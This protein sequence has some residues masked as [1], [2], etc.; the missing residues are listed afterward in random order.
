MGKRKIFCKVWKTLLATVLLVT[1]LGAGASA[2]GTK[3][4]DM[5]RDANGA[6]VY[7][8]VEADYSTTVYHRFTVPSSGLLAVSGNQFN[9]YSGTAYGLS[10]SLCDS[11]FRPLDQYS[12]GAY[13]NASASDIEFYGVSAGTYY[14]KVSGEKM[15]S[16]AAAFEKVSD[17]AGT[18]K[19]KAKT[20]KQKKVVT[21]V[22]AAGEKAKKADWYKFKVTKNKKLKLEIAAAGNGYTEFY[23]YGPSYSKKGTRIDSLKNESGTYFSI[24]GLTRKKLKVKPGTYYIRVKRASYDKQ[25]SGIYS[26]KWQL[27]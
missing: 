10:V 23:L 15:Y 2:A 17:K 14:L 26:I 27:K 20:I 13:V 24:N 1:A 8:G 16:V 12:S 6:Y 3:T 11:N 21:G 9:T 4:V 22:L 7:A 25:G 18:S 5:S 19:A